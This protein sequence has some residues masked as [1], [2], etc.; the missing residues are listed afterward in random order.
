MKT[1]GYARVSAKDQNLA[2]QLD[3]FKRLGIPRQNIYA[4]KS[5]GKDFCRTEYLKLRGVLQKDDLL[6]VQSLDRLGRNYDQ[7][8]EEWRKITQSIG[9]NILVLDMPLLDTRSRSDTLLGKFV[10]NLVLEVLSFVA[11][12]ERSNIRARQAEGIR[13]AKER[14]AENVFVAKFYLRCTKLCTRENLPHRFSD[15]TFPQPLR[16]LQAARAVET[17][18]KESNL[19]KKRTWETSQVLFCSVTAMPSPCPYGSPR[20]SPPF[21][22]CWRRYKQSTFCRRTSRGSRK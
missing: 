5:S 19:N 1:Y 22:P 12:N 16:F 7:I 4:E 13:L 10:S 20:G 14:G 9:A 15:G 3:S 18:Q 6:V 2:R 11:E 21:R 8:T 17:F